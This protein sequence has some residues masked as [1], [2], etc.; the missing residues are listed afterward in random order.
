MNPCTNQL[1]ERYLDSN[2]RVKAWPGKAKKRLLVLAYLASKFEPNTKYSEQEV[3]AILMPLIED[4]VTRRRD[5]IE[6]HF[7]SRTADGSQY[8][9]N[10]ASTNS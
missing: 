3:N 2:G 4:Y 9:L 10:M 6:Y 7:L 8:W 1:L 5:L